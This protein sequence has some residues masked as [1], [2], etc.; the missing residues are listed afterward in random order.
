MN[1]LKTCIIDPL[2]SARRGHKSLLCSWRSVRP[3]ARKHSYKDCP[4]F[5]FAKSS[6]ERHRGALH[7]EVG[8]SRCKPLY[9]EWINNKSLLYSIE[10]YIQYPIIS[11]IEKEHVYMYIYMCITFLYSRN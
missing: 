10:N 5:V 3:K 8:T 7:W 2:V 4:R 6:G 1:R 11:H 9:I